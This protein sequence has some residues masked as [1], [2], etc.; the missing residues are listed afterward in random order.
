M[1]QPEVDRRVAAT[2]EAIRRDVAANGLYYRVWLH[3]RE[4]G[5]TG[6]PGDRAGLA[7]ELEKITRRAER[8]RRRGQEEGR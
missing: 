2:I 8:N 7:R 6:R 5:L 1:P 4:K 3:L